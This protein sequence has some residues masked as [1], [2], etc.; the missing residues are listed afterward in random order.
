MSN[1]NSKNSDTS[2]KLDVWRFLTITVSST[3]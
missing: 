2:R 3:I 1:N